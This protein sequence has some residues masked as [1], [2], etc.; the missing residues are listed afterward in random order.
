[1]SFEGQK[2]GETQKETERYS[3][4]CEFSIC[5]NKDQKTLILNFVYKT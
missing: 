2:R 5:K 3:K 4:A 1:M